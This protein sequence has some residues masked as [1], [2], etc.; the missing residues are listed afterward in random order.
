MA[1]SISIDGGGVRGLSS[2]LILQ[3]LMASINS[4]VALL[5]KKSSDLHPYHIFQ[6]AAGTS[7]GGLIALM[8]GKMGMTVDECISQYEDLSKKIFG[9]KHLRGRMTHGLAPARYS[10]KRLQKCIRELLRLRQ[11]DENMSMKQSHADDKMACA[12]ICREHTSPSQYSKLKH[13][14]VPICSLPCKDNVDCEVCDA[15]RATSAAPTFFPVMCIKDRFFADGGLAHNNPSFA[16]YFHYT[17]FESKKTTRRTVQTTNS[18]PAFS[19]HGDLDCSCVR[20]T[21]IGTGAKIEEVEPGKRERLAGLVPGAIRRGI[22]LKQTLKEIAVNAEEKADVMRQFQALNDEVFMYERFDANHGVSNI[23]LDDYNALGDIRTKTEGYLGQQDTKELLDE[24]GKSIANDYVNALPQT[25][26]DPP[27]QVQVTVSNPATPA[28]S[29]QESMPTP[30]SSTFTSGSTP[31]S[32]S[33]YSHVPDARLNMGDNVQGGRPV[34]SAED[35]AHLQKT[36][37]VTQSRLSHEDSGVY[38]LD[39]VDTL[40][41]P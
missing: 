17:R 30:I 9:K 20:F 7:T 3:A 34:S 27:D 5:L 11:L 4:H 36:G 25:P 23:K 16:I 24:V 6:L 10:G 13:K 37:I 32:K 21:N 31:S 18:A 41:E 1:R 22:F 28:Q 19:V 2:L 39:I 14:A 12:V 26:C 15:A 35:P 40:K 38:D 33:P 8:L 29:A